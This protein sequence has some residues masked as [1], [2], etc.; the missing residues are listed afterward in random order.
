M[1]GFI[2]EVFQ[3]PLY[4]TSTFS[5]E[6]AEQGERRFLGEEAG[7]VYS[8]LGNP[9]VSLLEDQNDST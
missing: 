1:N 2:T 8:R 5:F 7:H 6:S 3:V 4:Q 9:T